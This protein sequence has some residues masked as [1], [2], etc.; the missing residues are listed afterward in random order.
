M[1]ALF[2]IA[3]AA[4]G[5][6]WKTNQQREREKELLY[7]GNQVEAAIA[8]YYEMGRQF[9]SELSDLVDDT[10]WP[11]PRHFLRKLYKDPMTNA[12]DWTLI[13]DDNGL[14]MGIASSSHGVPLKK[15]GFRTDEEDLFSQAQTYA[16]WQFIFVPRLG[17]RRRLPTPTSAN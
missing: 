1:V 13:R 8:S 3:L 16:D 9:P 5:V 10:R 15:T 6:V 4:T 12:V 7:I 14:I 11:E 2:G 17:W